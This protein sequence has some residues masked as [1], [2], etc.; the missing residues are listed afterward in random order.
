[1]AALEPP[2]REMAEA[3]RQL[4]LDAGPE[5]LLEGRGNK[6]RHVKVKRSDN[7]R[8][9]QFAAWVQEAVALNQRS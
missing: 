2:V 3:L 9:G 6:M 1:M 4:V 7:I 8:A 5:R